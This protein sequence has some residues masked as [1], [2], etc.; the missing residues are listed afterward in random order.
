MGETEELIRMAAFAHVRRLSET[1]DPLTSNELKPGFMFRDERIPLVNPQRGI[2]KTVVMTDINRQFKCA[3]CQEL[4]ELPLHLHELAMFSEL[5]LN[6]H[7]VYERKKGV[8]K[9]KGKAHTKNIAKWL[10]LASQL[11]R[12]ELNPFRYEE[13]H[14]YCEPV[15]DML[16]SNAQHHETIITPLTRFIYVANAL[17]EIYRFI[18]PLYEAAYD[19][20]QKQSLKPEHIRTYSAQSAYLLEKEQENIKLPRHYN[21]LVDN[22]LKIVKLYTDQFHSHFDMDLENSKGLSF[23]LC[24]VRNIRNQI[25]HGSFPIIEDPEYTC[26]FYEPHTKRNI[27]NL[28]G[29]ASRISAINIQMLLAMASD[30]LG[31]DEHEASCMDYDYGDYFKEHCT[32]HYLLNL[33]VI[34]DFGLNESD[35][36][37]FSSEEDES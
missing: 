3:K 2:F 17:E 34:Q 8:V 26:E 5:L 16:T 29:Q 23:G 18:S 31:S 19:I 36:F 1:H 20:L 33:H 28:L 21:H 7:N 25:A 15:N 12:V 37:A 6:E 30:G 11:E 4:R 9:Q 27:I 14:I 22:F 13:A 32:F 35:Y 24:L 10:R